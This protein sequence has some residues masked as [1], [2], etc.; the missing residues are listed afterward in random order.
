MLPETLVLIFYAYL[1]LGAIFALYFVIW[2]A[3]RIDSDAHH[4]PVLL[5]LLLWPASVALWP[6]LLPKLWQTNTDKATRTHSEMPAPQ[7]NA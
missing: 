6:M 1:G 7:P 5:R 4:L 2:G 3:A